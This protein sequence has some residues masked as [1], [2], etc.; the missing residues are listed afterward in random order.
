MPTH[1]VCGDSAIDEMAKDASALGSSI[2]VVSDKGLR[3]TGFIDTVADKLSANGASVTIF[4]DV[5]P[6]PTTNDVDTAALLR[7]QT[8]ADVIVAI[9]GGSPMDAAKGVALLGTNP[10]SISDYE[11][12]VTL[13]S[14]PL[15]LFTVPTTV[16][17]GAE[18]S[19]ASVLTNVDES[20]KLIVLSDALYP[21]AA[22]LDPDSVRS[23]PGSIAAA[24]GMDALTHAIEAFVGKGSNQMSD[25]IALGAI[26]MIGRNLRAAHSGN[27]AAL[28]KML[29][30]SCMA[31]VAFCSAGLG[32]VHGY[33][34]TL[35]GKYPI[36]HG[37]A[38]AVMLPWVMEFNAEECPQKFAEIQSAL[39]KSSNSTGSASASEFV[40]KL[41][42]DIELPTRLKDLDVPKSDLK[43]IAEGTMKSYDRGGNPRSSSLL[44]L[45][46]MLERAW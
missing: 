37:I 19:N 12:Y 36:H 13:S 40:R 8:S 29:I 25:A 28:F 3:A 38:N 27:P 15:P 35:G 45:L 11:G 33:A 6:N 18:I 7:E 46:D 16:G 41:M 5:S 43:S 21:S 44:Q 22:Y 23:L 4:D 10:G 34:M 1:V 26:E 2:L 17:T 39:E 32:L 42:M 30:A 24:T 14:K 31:G 9:G 20:R